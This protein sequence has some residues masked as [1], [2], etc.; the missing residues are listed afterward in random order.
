ME[1]LVSCKIHES[2]CY[3]VN[4]KNSNMNFVNAQNLN[5]QINRQLPDTSHQ[6]LEPY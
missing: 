6:K 4:S 2:L 3:T 1:V 5:N